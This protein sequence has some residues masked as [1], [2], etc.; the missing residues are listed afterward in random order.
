MV[1]QRYY[2]FS[3]CQEVEEKKSGNLSLKN[4]SSS[5]SEAFFIKFLRRFKKI[6]AEMFE[7]A[8]TPAAHCLNIAWGY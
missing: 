6:A 3:F 7:M 1:R 4:A 5:L 2:G 8:N